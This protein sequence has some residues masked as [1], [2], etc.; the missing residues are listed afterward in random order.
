M[1]VNIL[2]IST[3]FK[4]KNQ[5]TTSKASEANETPYICYMIMYTVLNKIVQII[6]NERRSIS[7]IVSKN[8]GL[9]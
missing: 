4:S 9:L 8:S 7:V 6:L 2:R 1:N 3:G 5:L